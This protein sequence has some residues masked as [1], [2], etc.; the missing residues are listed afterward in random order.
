MTDPLDVARSLAVPGRRT[1]LVTDFDG[2]LAPIVDDP[3]ASALLEGAAEV[4]TSLA[5]RLEVVALLSGRPVGFLAERA[6][7]PGVLLLGSYGVE[8]WEDGEAHVLPEVEAW[9]PAVA[10]ASERLHAEFDGADGVHVEDKGLAV[11]VHWRRAPDQAAAGARTS[12]VVDELAATLGLH[13]EPGKLVQELR[14]PLAEDKGTAL[15]RV[16]AEHDLQHVAYAGDDRGDLPA[17]AAVADLGGHALVVHSPEVAPE[18][19]AVP[20]A[21]FEGPAAFLDWL[22]TLDAL[23]AERG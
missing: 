16:V 5:A 4:L 22:R 6:G 18:V 10:T 3:A 12:A 11:A 21:V 23:L 2:V 20:G 7:L 14:A 15:R 1:G 13:R 8:H 17:F 19:A 9:R